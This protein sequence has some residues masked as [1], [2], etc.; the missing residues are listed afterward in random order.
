[1]N[2]AVWRA[3]MMDNMIYVK[4]ENGLWKAIK[5][6]LAVAAISFVA[7]KVYQ[8]FFKKKDTELEVEELDTALDP[9]ELDLADE[10]TEAIDAFEVSADAVIANVEDMETESADAEA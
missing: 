8:M 9:I 4:K 3:Q 2:G 10:E 7:Y 5:I 1:M 6:V